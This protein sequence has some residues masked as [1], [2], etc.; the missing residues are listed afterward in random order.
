MNGLEPP[1][2]FASNHTSHLDTPA[3]FTAPPHEWSKRLAPA[4]MQDHFRAY[5]EPE[6][7]SWLDVVSAGLTYFLTCAFYNT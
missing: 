4:M 1:V 3:I 7:F 2:I 6:R 5:F